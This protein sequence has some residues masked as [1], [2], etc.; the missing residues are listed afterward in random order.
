MKHLHYKDHD[1]CDE[2]ILS[3]IQSYIITAFH[4]HK[5]IFWF[6]IVQIFGSLYTIAC[7]RSWQVTINDYRPPVSQLSSSFSHNNFRE[8][9]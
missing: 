9:I 3:I 6:R 2:K 7:D 4:D 1:Q 5:S 8:T